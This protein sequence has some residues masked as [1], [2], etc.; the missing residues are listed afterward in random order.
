MACVPCFIIMKDSLF[1]LVKTNNT[2]ISQHRM[3]YSSCVI[4]GKPNFNLLQQS[5]RETVKPT[6]STVG[7]GN[8]EA[9]GA[10]CRFILMKLITVF[11]VTVFKVCCYI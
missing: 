9:S 8:L 3:I 4:I 1:E 11:K 7:M 6:S 10:P 2:H 5:A